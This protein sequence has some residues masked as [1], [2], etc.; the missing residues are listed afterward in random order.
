MICDD[1]L[2]RIKEGDPYWVSP[3]DEDRRVELYLVDDKKGVYL[4]FFNG[5]AETNLCIT[6]ETAEALGLALLHLD[7]N[8]HPD[9]WKD[10]IDPLGKTGDG[11]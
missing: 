3:V 2:I 8:L 4:K 5:Q 6:I 9:N 1:R 7:A 10:F 11:T